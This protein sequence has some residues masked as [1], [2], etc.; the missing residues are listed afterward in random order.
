MIECSY[1]G[2]RKDGTDYAKPLQN[3]LSQDKCSSL[4]IIKRM[5]TNRDSQ[6]NPSSGKKIA[7]KDD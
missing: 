2:I 4:V 6:E 1:L 7:I 5:G 3:I